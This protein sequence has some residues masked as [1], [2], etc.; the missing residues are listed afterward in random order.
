MEPK[1]LDLYNKFLIDRYAASTA[2]RY[3]KWAAKLIC[4]HGGKIH[5]EQM[6]AQDI[7]EFL[8][9]GREVKWYGPRTIRQI[10]SALSILFNQYLERPGI[11]GPLR[12]RARPSQFP[13]VILSDADAFMLLDNL[14]DDSRILC[15]LMY[16]SGL[17]VS[18]ALSLSAEQLDFDA[19]I[20]AVD[21][22]KTILPDTLKLRLMAKAEN[23]DPLFSISSQ[24]LNRHI[25][26]AATKAGVTS[27]V[28][29]K[30]FRQAFIIS[31]F[32]YGISIAGIRDATGM[33]VRRL[34]IYKSLA[35]KRNVISPL[36]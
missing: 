21:G 36:D 20:I 27:V 34:M 1:F 7:V 13:L 9:H 31:Q 5:P 3:R 33:S 23:G 10:Y 32:H 29:A 14:R 4:Y 18:E 28:S 26:K 2:Y 35:E 12:S 22:R 8:D 19:G 16:G 30:I 25:K 17:R 24:V 15:Q 11:I 6:V